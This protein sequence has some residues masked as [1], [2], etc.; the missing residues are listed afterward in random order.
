MLKVEPRGFTERI[1]GG[2]R[3]SKESGMTPCIIFEFCCWW[4]N[5]LQRWSLVEKS[6]IGFGMH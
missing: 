6:R 1:E 4:N 5:N 2:S 3:L